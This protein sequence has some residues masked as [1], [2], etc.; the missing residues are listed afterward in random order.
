M[1]Q[2]SINSYVELDLT[3]AGTQT[4]TIQLPDGTLETI[5]ITYT[6]L[7]TPLYWEETRHNV[8][9]TIEVSANSLLANRGFTIVVDSGS[10]TNA[11]GEWYSTGLCTVTSERF[12]WDRQTASYRLGV[13]YIGGVGSRTLLLNA[14]MI[15]ASKTLVISGD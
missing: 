11:Y 8:A 6:P 7:P 13:D 5:S 9:G 3:Q 10:I 4:E 15:Q 14:R 1:A 12:T 2:E